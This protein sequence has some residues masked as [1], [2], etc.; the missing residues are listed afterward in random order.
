MQAGIPPAAVVLLTFR[1][2][3]CVRKFFCGGR[4]LTPFSVHSSS[5]KSDGRRG[6]LP[7]NSPESRGYPADRSV[8]RC[9][10]IG[11]RCIIRIMRKEELNLETEA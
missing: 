2:P 7:V 9:T 11:L 3:V 6:C 1:M 8:G 10:L 4:I 5:E